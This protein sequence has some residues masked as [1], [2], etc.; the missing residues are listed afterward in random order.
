MKLHNYRYEVLYS[1]I[2][3][4]LLLENLDV[5]RYMTV[6]IKLYIKELIKTL[7]CDI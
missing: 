4:V 7:K 1:Q 2:T 6:K 5:I 3:T